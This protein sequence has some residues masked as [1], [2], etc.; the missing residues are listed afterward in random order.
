MI[1]CGIG[2]FV[3]VVWCKMGLCKGGVECDMAEFTEQERAVINLVAAGITDISKACKMVGYEA[4]GAKAIELLSREEFL[5]AV[6]TA[7]DPETEAIVQSKTARKRFWARVMN[8]VEASHRDKI[9][10]SELLAKASGDFVDQV[11]V[12]FSPM[13]LLSALEERTGKRDE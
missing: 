11:N 4:P 2:L 3:D 10:A 5:N 1:L 8:D 6:D 7:A 9:R 13:G 12:N